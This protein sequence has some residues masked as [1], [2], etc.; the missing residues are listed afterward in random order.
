[1]RGWLS[2]TG[3]V[4]P[5]D[6]VGYFQVQDGQLVLGSYTPNPR[7]LVFSDSGLVRLPGA[8]HEALLEALLWKGVLSGRVEGCQ[9]I[10]RSPKG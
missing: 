3:H 10:R 9:T 6:I 5:E 1:M 4:P 2:S 8:L 7:H